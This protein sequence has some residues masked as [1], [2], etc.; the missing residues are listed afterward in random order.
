[1]PIITF[2]YFVRRCPTRFFGKYVSNIDLPAS[3]GIDVPVRK[4]LVKTL[5]LENRVYAIE[6]TYTED[7][8]DIG[9][10]SYTDD[11]AWT[12]YREVHAFDTYIEVKPNGKTRRWTMGDRLRKRYRLCATCKPGGGHW[13]SVDILLR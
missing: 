12:T 6:S 4:E 8:V 1:M 7:D 3:L 13:P 11:N 2:T 5:N 9:V 10:L